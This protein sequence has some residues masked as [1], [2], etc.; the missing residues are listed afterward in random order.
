MGL[1]ILMSSMQKV[2]MMQRI[3][4]VMLPAARLSEGGQLL[5]CACFSGLVL[6]VKKITWIV[7][8]FLFI[9]YVLYFCFVCLL[10][11]LFVGSVI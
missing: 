5:R 3:N 1:E 6:I 9:F 8:C 11:F 10:K 2:E 4:A 7:S